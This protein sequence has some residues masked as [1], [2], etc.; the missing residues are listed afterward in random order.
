VQEKRLDDARRFA[1]EVDATDQ[2]AYLFFQIASAALKDKDRFRAAEI[3]HEAAQ[4]ATA[5]DNTP[6]KLR[7]LSG[8][9]HLY[10]GIDPQRA[11][12]VAAEAVRAANRV[13]TYGPGETRLLRSLETP[14]GQGSYLSVN[15][16]REF[17]LGKMLAV[18]AR[19]DFDG[20]LL[21]AESLENKSLRL[22]A[23]VTLA[24]SV[25]DKKQVAQV[26]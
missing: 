24:A 12:E 6:E 23:I 15:D 21:L 4:Q 5:A 17:D 7:A 2:R 25:F 8:I 16:V 9:A 1:L 18:L 22:A 3:L 19:T 14:G 13:P 10:A 11:F 26:Q 20:A